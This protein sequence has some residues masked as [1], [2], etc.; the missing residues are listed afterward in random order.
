MDSGC[1]VV[2]SENKACFTRNR[3]RGCRPMNRPA[4]F[5][6]F[7]AL[8]PKDEREE[9]QEL[10]E[11]VENEVKLRAEERGVYISFGPDSAMDLVMAVWSWQEKQQVR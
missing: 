7:L 6:E 9:Y 1:D 11:A 3:K 4:K 5:R 2:V 10:L 8:L